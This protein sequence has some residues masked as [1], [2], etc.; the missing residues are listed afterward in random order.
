MVFFFVHVSHLM[1]KT[2][3][4]SILIKYLLGLFVHDKCIPMGKF[5]EMRNVFHFS[6]FQ[7]FSF[8]LPLQRS[9]EAK[10]QHIMS[11]WCDTMEYVDYIYTMYNNTQRVYTHRVASI[12]IFSAHHGFKCN[13]MNDD[14]YPT[15][16][17]TSLN[18][19]RHMYAHAI[20]IASIQS[21]RT[22]WNGINETSVKEMRMREAKKKHGF[23]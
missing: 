13:V 16:T 17:S 2:M 10:F 18:S 14:T 22:Q 8:E 19:Y 4:F 1:I 15:N 12:E 3:E 23:M 11:E 9:P 21:K 7:K 20:A 5:N 6:L